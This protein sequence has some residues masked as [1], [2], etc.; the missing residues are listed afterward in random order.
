MI[1]PSGHWLV[2]AAF[3]L[4]SD[5]GFNQSVHLEKRGHKLSDLPVTLPNNIKPVNAFVAQ[6]KPVVLVAHEAASVTLDELNGLLQAD[7]ASQIHANLL[8]PQP[9][10]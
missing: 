2:N 8:V 5:P 1:I 10:H 3:S 9:R 6:A 7:L 4:L